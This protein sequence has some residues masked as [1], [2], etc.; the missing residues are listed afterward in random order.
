[1]VEFE[2]DDALAAAAFLAAKNK[3]VDRI[4]ICT[5]DK[6]L[7]Q[8]VQGTRIVQ[9]DRRKRLIRDE[10][11]VIT[12]FGVSPA[13]IPDY[14][15]LVGDAADGYPGLRGWG[16]KSASAVLARYG[17]LEQIPTDWRE[18]GLNLASPKTLSE[19]LLDNQK[20]VFLFRD[21]ATLRTDIPLFASV[22]QLKWNGA[23]ANFPVFAARLDASLKSKG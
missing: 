8:C 1:M 20:L 12:K 21:L 7:S 19:T 2:A 11:G 14:L 6:D 4:F 18:W 16:A 13:S 9:L 22:Q 10:A 5:P 17:H 23:A 15:A 3:N